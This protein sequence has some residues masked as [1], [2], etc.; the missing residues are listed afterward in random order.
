MTVFRAPILPEPEEVHASA[1]IAELRGVAR[2]LLDWKPGRHI[3]H[4]LSHLSPADTDF[5]SQA[6][7]NGEVSIICGSTIQAQESVMAGVWRVRE[8]DGSG[9]PVS[10]RIELGPF[11]QSILAR[12]FVHARGSIDIPASFGPGVFNAPP[13]LAEIN[14][15]IARYSPDN[16]HAHVINLSLLPHTEDDLALLD[17]LLGK[18]SVTVLSRGY[19]NCRVE[20]TGLRYVWWVRFFNSQDTLILNT[21]EVTMLPDVVLASP[22]DIADSADRLT[23][24]MAVY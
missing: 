23:E 18:G 4:G 5:V 8:S 24:I 13:L 3:T 2:G 7:G 17:E 20:A 21:I 22:E 16:P 14:E 19:G 11:P 1:A 15:A 9:K 6:L 10:D 12:T